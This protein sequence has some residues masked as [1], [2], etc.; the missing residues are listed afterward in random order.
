MPS[1]PELF[2]TPTLIPN[3]SEAQDRPHFQ[4][5]ELH[6]WRAN[7]DDSRLLALAGGVLSASEIVRA[8]RTLSPRGR[9]RELAQ[10][11]L[12]RDVLGRYLGMD[13]EAV[14]FT[15]DAQGRPALA[16]STLRFVLAQADEIALLA[17][18]PRGE[19]GLE[20]ERVRDD[21]PFDDM[22]AHFFDPE[23]H[24]GVR[25]TRCPSEK[26]L[27]FF[28][29]WTRNEAWQQAARSERVHRLCPAEGFAAALAV[30]DDDAQFAFWEWR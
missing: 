13:P 17:V 25:I 16:L 5:N 10:S 8:E 21:L 4:R 26:A 23:D 30:G 6:L 14:A 18:A 7:L 27:K 22:A 11:A 29:C 1:L 12:L 19:F 2:E 28:D 24:W 3:W 15:R 20:I 9:D